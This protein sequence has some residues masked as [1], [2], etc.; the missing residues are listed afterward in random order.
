MLSDSNGSIPHAG[1]AIQEAAAEYLLHLHA[2]RN[3]QT[4]QQAHYLMQHFVRYCHAHNLHTLEQLSRRE[5]L[6]FL[7]A[8]R[9][10]DFAE[11]TVRGIASVV[12][13]FL[14]WCAEEGL[15][16]SIVRPGDLPKPPAPNPQPMSV[17]QIQ[18]VLQA[19]QGNSWVD[20][21]NRAL[22]VCALDT[23]LRR[24]E[25][26]QMTVEHAHTGVVVV[27]QKGNRFHSVYLT[28][29]TQ[30]AIRAY[31]RAF[32]FSTGTRLNPN[33]LL[34]RSVGGGVMTGN[35]VRCVF[36]RLSDALGER[37]YAHR[38]RAT[39]ITLRLALGAST[40]VVRDAVGHT[41]DRSLRHYAK[42]AETDRARLLRETSPLRA[43]RRR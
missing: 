21:R 39:S 17:E 3:A 13:R 18:R 1:V 5:W 25:L 26:L 16:A 38:L 19:F 12:G 4:A 11:W 31:L 30:Q 29:E 41:D 27:R 2:V 15:M 34:W 28:G 22:V 10:S 42:L 23:G 9:Q 35:A 14:K 20:K 43:L 37:V 32:T 36:R 6:R 33:D 8:L 40:E 24:A 7:H